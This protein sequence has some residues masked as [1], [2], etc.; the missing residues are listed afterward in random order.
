M[1][2]RL[3]LATVVLALLSAGVVGFNLFRDRMIEAAFAEMG[4]QPQAVAVHEVEPSPWQPGLTGFGTVSATRGVMLVLEAEGRIL[5]VTFDGNQTV[6]E[7]DLLVRV[8]DDMQRADLAAAV[9]DAWLAEQALDRAERLGETGTA[10][11]ATVEEAAA[12]V[13]AAQ[14]QVARLEAALRRTRLVAPFEGEVGIPQI[15][16]GAFAEAGMQ[17]A[18]LQRTDRV[19]VDFSIPER[20]V[21]DIA[22]GQTVQIIGEGMEGEV[23]AIEPRT[24]PDSRLVTVRAPFDNADA[25]LRPGQFVRVRVLLDP[26]DD[27]IA[28][29]QTAVIN[30]LFGDH[31]FALREVED[32]EHDLEVRQVFVELGDRDGDRIE[33]TDGLEAGDRVVTA[34]QNRL[35]NRTPVTVDPDE[36][37]EE[38]REAE[39]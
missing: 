4:P 31:V 7:G 19:W 38:Q 9:A 37:E 24:D 21:R 2:L 30:S 16:A 6:E 23:S 8:E 13:D 11:E 18:S 10:A 39:Q 17:V 25:L 34:G 26:R 12:A 28:V 22:Q 35:S 14:A 27:V 3:I 20:Q 33:I 29:P 1:T 36:A 15:E 32:G 5:E